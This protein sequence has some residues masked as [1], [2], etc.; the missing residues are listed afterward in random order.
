MNWLVEKSPEE[1]REFLP[2]NLDNVTTIT[3]DYNSRTHDKGETT[4]TYAVKFE[5]NSAKGDQWVKWWFDDK[6]TRDKYYNKILEK[7]PRLDL[8][9]G[10]L[11]L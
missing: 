7:L 4:Y 9:I 11:S 5:F 1:K 3:K 10:E 6:D 2:I 8:G